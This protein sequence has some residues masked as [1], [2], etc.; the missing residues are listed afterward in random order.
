MMAYI[1]LKHNR[2]ERQKGVVILPLKEYHRLLTRAIPTY[3]LTGKA[4]E[5]VDKLVEE[6]MREY[7]E[8][9]TIRA[10]SLKEALRLYA[11]KRAR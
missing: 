8:G 7:R 11:R 4:A 6:G 2:V 1:T 3:Y 9:K 10:G 5:R